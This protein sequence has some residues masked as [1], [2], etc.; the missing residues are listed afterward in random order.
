MTGR[1]EA[2]SFSNINEKFSKVA[3]MVQVL[4]RTC[5][6]V[7]HVNFYGVPCCS[8]SICYAFEHWWS[9]IYSPSISVLLQSFRLWCVFVIVSL[10]CFC[11][12]ST[13]L[14]RAVLYFRCV[15]LTVSRVFWC[16]GCF[17]SALCVES[18]I[19]QVSQC[20]FGGCFSEAFGAAEV[21]M[22]L[23]LPF[24][25]PYI[26]LGRPLKGPTQL[27]VAV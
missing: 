7:P 16:M 8:H 9:E 3:C 22:G 24:K 21:H 13:A 11:G 14:S 23:I 25:G 27:Y 2:T 12:A 6:G 17:S 20:S 5:L 18:S 1:G 10:V 15:L 19:Q 26:A 4:I